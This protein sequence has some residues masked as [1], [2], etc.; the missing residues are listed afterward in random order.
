MKLFRREKY[1][2]RICSSVSL[3]TKAYIDELN[4]YGKEPFEQ[5]EDQLV[6]AI[7]KLVK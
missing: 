1:I 7:N 4:K 3:V 2:S 6:K 5:F